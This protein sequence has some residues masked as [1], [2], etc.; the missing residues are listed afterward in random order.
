MHVTIRKLIALSL[1]LCLG[2][3]GFANDTNH[4]LSFSEW[5]HEKYMVALKKLSEARAKKPTDITQAQWDVDNVRDLNIN[6]YVAVYLGNQ[7]SPEAV[8]DAVAKLSRKETQA[9]LEGYVRT[10]KRNQEDSF[11]SDIPKSDMP[12]M[13]RANVE[14]HEN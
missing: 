1:T 10:L 2:L 8:K 6:D 3:P 12:R 13:R 4:V 9:L 14:T 7:N 11:K 5:K